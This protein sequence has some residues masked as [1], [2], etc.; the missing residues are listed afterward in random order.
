MGSVSNE[1]SRNLIF[2]EWTSKE[3]SCGFTS[4]NN[5]IIEN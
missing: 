2:Q 4:Q 5:I 1:K 3:D